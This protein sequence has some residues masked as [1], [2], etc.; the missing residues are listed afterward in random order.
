MDNYS[1]KYL[2]YRCPLR[3]PH[4]QYRCSTRT[5]L[6]T[7]TPCPPWPHLCS[8]SQTQG[9]FVLRRMASPLFLL[10]TQA[11]SLYVSSPVKCIVVLVTCRG[12]RFFPLVLRWRD[13]FLG[14]LLSPISTFYESAGSNATVERQLTMWPSAGSSDEGTMSRDLFCHRRKFF[15]F[16]PSVS[17]YRRAVIISL[18]REEEY[19][20]EPRR[21]QWTPSTSSFFDY[22][23][24]NSQECS[25]LLI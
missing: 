25:G 2:V 19:T 12:W 4:S 23:C 8:Y 10:N 16:N 11:L 3:P 20:V 5:L 6:H 7:R 18:R 22:S 21:G 14:L 1:V 13:I 15:E 24:T 17:S 9:L